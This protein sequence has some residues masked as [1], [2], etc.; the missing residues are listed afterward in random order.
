MFPTL[1]IRQQLIMDAVRKTG[2]RTYSD[3]KT[4]KELDALIRLGL[5]K[6]EAVELDMFTLDMFTTVV[7]S[8]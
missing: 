6:V 1:T 3:E 2:R 4:L 7:P 8:A 5:L